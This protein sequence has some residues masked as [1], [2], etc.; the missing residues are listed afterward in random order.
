MLKLK[1]GWIGQSSKKGAGVR[2]GSKAGEG[3]FRREHMTRWQKGQ[4]RLKP[5]PLPVQ[6]GRESSDEETKRTGQNSHLRCVNSKRNETKSHQ[7]LRK[8]GRIKKMKRKRGGR[9]DVGGAPPNYSPTVGKNERG[10]TT[11]GLSRL[12]RQ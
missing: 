1:L 4:N 5:T 9:K 12:T 10:K 3:K 11:R 6:P 7:N 8:R 2:G